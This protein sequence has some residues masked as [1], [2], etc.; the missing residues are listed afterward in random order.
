VQWIGEA[1]VQIGDPEAPPEPDVARFL[2]GF[3]QS[4]EAEAGVEAVDLAQ[5]DS[6]HRVRFRFSAASRAGAEQF[7]GRVA[8]DALRQGMAA[9]ENPDALGWVVPRR[10]RAG[11]R[12]CRGRGRGRG[13]RR[14]GPP[15]GFYPAAFVAEDLD[16]RFAAL[17]E[18]D[19]P[20]PFGFTQGPTGTTIERAV[21]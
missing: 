12:C 4:V 6:T 18:L 17:V 13:W 8:A 21:S 11:R 15:D 20:G 3:V 5:S 2:A 10:L 1:Q 9:T 14:P 7:T 19:D 16:G